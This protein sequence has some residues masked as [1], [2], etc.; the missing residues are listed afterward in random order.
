MLV[1]KRMEEFLNGEKREGK[2]GVYDR[3]QD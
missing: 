1:A 3:A 2:A